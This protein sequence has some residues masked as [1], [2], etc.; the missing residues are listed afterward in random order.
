LLLRSAAASAQFGF[1]H[2]LSFDIIKQQPLVVLLQEEDPKELKK[3]AKKPEE[4]ASYQAY[5]AYYNKQIQALAPQYWKYSPS[6]EFRPESALKEIRAAKGQRTVVLRYETHV[7]GA[8]ATIYN[9]SPIGSRRVAYMEL[10]TPGGG[11][12]HYEWGCPA[13]LD[14]LYPSD[15]IF[16]FRAI[17]QLLE[18]DMTRKT[19]LEAGRSRKDIE[20]EEEAEYMAAKRAGAEAIKAKTLLIA[21]VDLDPKLTAATIKELYPYPF[22]VV[23]RATIEA[24]AQAGDAR[25][26]YAR[27]LCQSV[28]VI[29]PVIID[30]ATSRLLATANTSG[31]GLGKSEVV[32]KDAFKIYTAFVKKYTEE[33]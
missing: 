4:L 17:Q 7:N 18:K 1:T 20:A 25:Y 30:A 2:F 5:I 12:Q 24:A 23:P 32:D 13:P 10:T 22:Q 15:I 9:K 6:V 29:G 21:E 33:K 31:V 8:P 11:D 14:M 3:L 19:R 16:A 28:E 26:T 27:R